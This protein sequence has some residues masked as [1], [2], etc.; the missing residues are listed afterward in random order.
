[1]KVLIKND[2]GFLVNGVNVSIPG[3]FR[4]EKFNAAEVESTEVLPGDFVVRNPRNFKDLLELS[5]LVNI[6][7]KVEVVVENV[8]QT[9]EFIRNEQLYKVTKLTIQGEVEEF[10]SDPVKYLGEIRNFQ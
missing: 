2:K 8:E 3:A 4:G 9:N 10:K 6:H 1:M 7:E 5:R